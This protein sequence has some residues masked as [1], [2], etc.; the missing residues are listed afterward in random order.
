MVLSVDAKGNVL[1]CQFTR[2]SGFDDLDKAAEEYL[3]KGWPV[4]PLAVAGQDVGSDL[5]VNIVWTT[6][7]D[8]IEQ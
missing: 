2:Q 7:P 1:N 6:L 3:T 4:T 5:F 8:E